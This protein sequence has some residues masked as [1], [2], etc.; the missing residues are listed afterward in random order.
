MQS[1]VN[2]ADRQREKKCAVF[3]E[4]KVADNMLVRRKTLTIMIL[5]LFAPVYIYSLI[6][7][8]LSATREQTAGDLREEVFHAE[9]GTCLYVV[10]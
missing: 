3:L 2:N 4:L 5:S 10:L 9:T 7:G 8:S 6:L 1:P